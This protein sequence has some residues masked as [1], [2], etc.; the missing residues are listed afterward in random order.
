MK[1]LQMTNFKTKNYKKII[2]NSFYF[3]YCGNI[4]NIYPSKI[5]FSIFTVIVKQLR[6]VKMEKI[7]LLGY[8]KKVKYLN[9]L[10]IIFRKYAF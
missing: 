5:S 8:I 2:I 3:I 6:I 4:F 7:I 9:L 1:N 10:L